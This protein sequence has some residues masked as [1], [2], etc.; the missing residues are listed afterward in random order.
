MRASAKFA[1]K[2]PVIL[3][4]LAN[5]TLTYL[6]YAHMA[7]GFPLYFKAD[8]LKSQLHISGS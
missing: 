8:Y 7:I 3:T 5:P 4:I 2:R 6:S 1:R